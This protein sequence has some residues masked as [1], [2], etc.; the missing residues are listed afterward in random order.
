MEKINQVNLWNGKICHSKRDK[1]GE[2]NCGKLQ[3][4]TQIN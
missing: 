3:D 2:R 4:V 1:K